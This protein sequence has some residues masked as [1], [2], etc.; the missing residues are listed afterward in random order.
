MPIVKTIEIHN[1]KGTENAEDYINDPDK[2]EIPESVKDVYE[3]DVNKEKTTYQEKRLVSGYKCNPGEH[4][5]RGCSDFAG[6]REA[7]MSRK[8]AYHYSEN[9][10][11]A[12]VES[13]HLVMS[14]VAEVKDPELV[15]QMGIEFVQRLNTLGIGDFQAVVSTHTNTEH[16]HNHILLNA[17]SMDGRRKLCMNKATREMMR[18]LSDEIA[19]EHGVPIID[20][21]FQRNTERSEKQ[22]EKIARMEG[23]SWKEEFRQDIDAVIDT[24]DSYEDWKHQMQELGYEIRER[25][26]GTPVSLSYENRHCRLD[27]LGDE[28]DYEK[29]IEK[30]AR[31]N[32]ID[33]ES[34]KVKPK[35]IP[36]VYLTKV[37]KYD[38]YGNR[39]GPL[40]MLIRQIVNYLKNMVKLFIA[41]G[42]EIEAE[43]M[44][45]K[46][47]Q[48]SK[49]LV[50]M[51]KYNIVMKSELNSA[52]KECGR[53]QRG[54][55]DQI[56]TF[57][58]TLAN[59]EAIKN[60]TMEKPKT[61]AEVDPMSPTQKKELFVALQN[62]N[63]DEK[64]NQKKGYRCY[65]K[66]DTVSS[67]E[68]NEILEFLALP[69]EDKANVPIPRPLQP[70]PVPLA[71]S[72]ER[73][74][75]ALVHAE[76][77]LKESKKE[78]DKQKD[79]YKDLMYLDKNV[80]E[81]EDIK[82]E[83]KS[84]EEQAKADQ[85]RK[86]AKGQK[87]LDP[88]NIEQPDDERD[89]WESVKQAKR[90]HHKRIDGKMKTWIDT[91]DLLPDDVQTLKDLE[92][93]L[94]ELYK[95]RSQS[96][97]PEAVE[98]RIIDKL[99]VINVAAE[100]AEARVLRETGRDV[101]QTR[102][103]KKNSAHTEI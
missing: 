60:G 84:Q 22:G 41:L 71:F 11:K 76:K 88:E 102:E 49:A 87:G 48:M 83:I 47:E 86:K 51:S 45:D 97:H 54:L 46:V 4:G 50:L 18:R 61:M 35:K 90:V 14:C 80:R 56:F 25:N 62:T 64:G 2:T 69:D 79:K 43:A 26:D 36:R 72:E 81:A 70:K 30:I 57:E 66:F 96:Q 73:M 103:Q 59:I 40:E 10:A 16:L 65:A 32:G 27:K 52:K 95:I 19:V 5:E 15:H 68:A 3:Y 92:A 44:N 20:E 28:W 63:L 93:D 7:Y 29:I 37:S 89:I 75:A 23:R 34:I 21:N 55:K 101:S 31:N 74:N 67:T 13:I 99:L 1:T 33:P 8:G 38:E 77:R 42:R 98:Q 85:Q 91:R 58:N 9:K 17:Y 53:L 39:R 12:P 100:R 78:L 6:P 82:S 24:A 94:I